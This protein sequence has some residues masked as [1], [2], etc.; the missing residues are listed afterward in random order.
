MKEEIINNWFIKDNVL[1]K[2]YN[3]YS[4]RVTILK[5]NINVFYRTEIFKH[6]KRRITF[7][8]YSL[9]DVITFIE[10]SMNKCLNEEEILKF[11]EEQF[12]ENRFK[13][14]VKSKL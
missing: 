9:E 14:L 7:N 11:Y 12:S 4:V 2:K 5:N 8:F 1:T 13:S 6:N 10:E 3:N